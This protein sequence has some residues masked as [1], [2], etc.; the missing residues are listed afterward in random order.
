[1]N[2]ER[3]ERALPKL[4][5]E[6]YEFTS[7]EDEIYNCIAWALNDTRQYWWPT[8]KYGCYWPPGVPRDN[9]LGSVKRIFELHGYRGCQT[10]NREAGYEKVALYERQDSG[11]EHVA[12]QLQSGEWTSKIGEWEDIRHPTLEVLEC[13]DY[14]SVTLIMKRLRPEWPT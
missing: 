9:T 1:M 11:V 5:T 7:N 14:G 12:R 10:G 8:P 3:L 4:S 6:A 2:K 13:E